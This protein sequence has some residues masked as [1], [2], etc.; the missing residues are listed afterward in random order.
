M[1]PM[2]R[3]LKSDASKLSSALYPKMLI[4]TEGAHVKNM[5][6][7][8]TNEHLQARCLLP[9]LPRLG[10]LPPETDL[11]ALPLI[12]YGAIRVRVTTASLEG[13]AEWTSL[14]GHHALCPSCGL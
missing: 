2:T 12:A 3:W 4:F 5:N 10:R 8:E 1:L 13:E 14:R 11:V 6:T 9:R 7:F